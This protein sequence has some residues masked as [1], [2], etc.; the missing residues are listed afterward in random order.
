MNTDTPMIQLARRMAASAPAANATTHESRR[1]DEFDPEVRGR[2]AQ[3]FE[4]YNG[5]QEEPQPWLRSWGAA[6]LISAA[7]ALLA[8]FLASAAWAHLFPPICHH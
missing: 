1:R 2:S 5:G 7:L 4:A 6:V 3:V 8:L